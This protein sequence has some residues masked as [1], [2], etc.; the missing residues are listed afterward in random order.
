M[1][2][3]LNILLFRMDPLPP[4]RNGREYIKKRKTVYRKLHSQIGSR[5]DGVKPGGPLER[6]RAARGHGASHRGASR[7]VAG[8]LTSILLVSLF[9]PTFPAAREAQGRRGGIV[10]YKSERR[11]LYFENDVL[12]Q[13]FPVV[14]GKRPEGVKRR[15]GDSRTPEGEYF[16]SSKRPRSRFRLF[17]GLSYPNARDAQ[18]G[19]R[20]GAISKTAYEGIRDAFRA[21]R[22]PAWDTALGGFV[23]IHGEGNEYRGFV[24]RHHIDWTDGCIALSNDDIRTLY[25]LV[26]VGT[27][28]LILP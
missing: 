26:H 24:R 25:D 5:H 11:L 15:R 21:W 12:K 10:V 4:F 9:G 3:D 14:L 28:V 7:W 6:R 19:L 13:R 18:E 8:A 17:L 20:R 23:G 2:T 16:V 22:E 1:E 27:P